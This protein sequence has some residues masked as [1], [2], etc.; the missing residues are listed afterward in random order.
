VALPLRD[1]TFDAALALWMLYHVPDKPSAL[2]E[3]RRVVRPDGRVFVTTNAAAFDSVFDDLVRR[4][5]ETTT[6]VIVERWLEPLDFD[7]E[8]G[9][10]ILAPHFEQV[11]RHLM[12]RDFVVPEAGPLVAY[13]DSARAPIEAEV[14]PV[15]WRSFL[16][17]LQ[18]KIEDR[19]RSGP[20]TY[21]TAQ[22]LFICS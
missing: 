2:S 12:R 4:A 18:R 1:S 20:V 5:I 10:D 15:P 22:C 13:V 17:A 21:S 9:H 8:N 6:G 3:L 14:G 19:L 11:E 7:A 16:D